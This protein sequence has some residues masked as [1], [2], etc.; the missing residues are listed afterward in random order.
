MK[1]VRTLIVR[2]D[3]RI[4]AFRVQSLKIVKGAVNTNEKAVLLYWVLMII[5]CEI[6]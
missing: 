4:N 2:I 3:E 1:A 6:N 5:Y